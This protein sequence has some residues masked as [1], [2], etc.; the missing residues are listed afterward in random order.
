MSPMSITLTPSNSTWFSK[1]NTQVRSVYE[2]NLFQWRQ[3]SDHR[4]NF[5]QN[6]NRN[7]TLSLLLSRLNGMPSVQST[8]S[9]SSLSAWPSS[10]ISSFSLAFGFLNSLG[11]S[12]SPSNVPVGES[13]LTILSCLAMFDDVRSVVLLKCGE[14]FPVFLS[15][16]TDTPPRGLTAIDCWYCERIKTVELKIRKFSETSCFDCPKSAMAAGDTNVQS[17]LTFGLFLRK[18]SNICIVL[19]VAKGTAFQAKKLPKMA[20]ADENCFRLSCAH[21]VVLLSILYCSPSSRN[22]KTNEN[23]TKTTRCA[24]SPSFPWQVPL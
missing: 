17:W 20:L 2:G 18:Q 6:S 22:Y 9:T 19:T 5:W 3:K 24:H 16:E 14:S 15:S 12:S 23:A 4:N 1:R 10:N 13:R 7:G 8:F 11:P 21:G